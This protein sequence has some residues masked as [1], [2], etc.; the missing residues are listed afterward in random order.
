MLDNETGA[1]IAAKSRV[2]INAAGAWASRFPQSKVKL[3]LTKGVHLIIDHARLPVPETV[4]MTEGPRILFAIPWGQRVILGTTDTDYDGSLE[5][6][7]CERSD[8]RY[9]LDVT[10][11]TF[12][13]ANLRPEDVISTYAG[14]RPLI[15]DPNGK[16]S[17]ISRAHQIITGDHGWIDVAGG[18]LPTTID[19]LAEDPEAWVTR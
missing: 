2:I 13:Q 1:S 19:R 3:R 8:V 17:D 15:A 6:P 12:P 5:H 4:V 9:I 11:A 18:K 10:N 14:L 16:P 7:T